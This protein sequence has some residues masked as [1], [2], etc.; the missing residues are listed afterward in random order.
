MAVPTFQQ[1]ATGTGT[2]TAT[3]TF[4]TAPA[5]YH[6]VIAI[7][8]SSTSH[9]NLAIT[10]YTKQ[11]FINQSGGSTTIWSKLCGAGESTSVTVTG[12]ATNTSIVVRSY[13]NLTATPLDQTASAGSTSATTL[14]LTTASTTVADELCI[15]GVGV[16]GTFSSPAFDNSFVLKQNIS[17]L[18]IGEKIIS[19]TGTV[20]VN[21]SWTTARSCHALI[22]TFK[23]G[24]PTP[25]PGRKQIG[26]SIKLRSGSGNASGDPTPYASRTSWANTAAIKLVNGLSSTYYPWNPIATYNTQSGTFDDYQIRENG[27]AIFDPMTNQWMQV[28]TTLDFNGGAPTIS[29]LLSNNGDQWTYHPQNPI[30]GSGTS[31]TT[32][33]E[34]PY[35]CKKLDG[36]MYRDSSGRALIYCEEIPGSEG[37]QRGVYLYRSAPYTLNDWTYAARVLDYGTVANTF[38]RSDRTSPIVIYTGDTGKEFVMLGEGR[39]LVDASPY[40][41][42]GEV[43]LAYSSDGLTFTMGNSGNALI[44]RASSGYWCQGGIVVDDIIKVGSSWVLLAHGQDGSLPGGATAFNHMGRWITTDQPADWT[45]SSFTEMAGNPFDSVTST[46]MFRGMED[47]YAFC[48]LN[49]HTL[50]F[51]DITTV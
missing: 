5:Q 2:T 12:G 36:T 44:T 24:D 23:G 47:G 50:H 9:V 33:G 41:N 4:S 46:V 18:F 42:E 27:N 32:R 26:Q 6:T 21:P 38:D 30:S 1:F 51:T 13:S 8:Y 48:E 49:R 28:Y 10:G 20:T 37:T 16:Q 39:N 11:G 45:S 29:A 22:V 35:I 40:Y 17:R 3:A 19:A 34:D 43:F 14:A 25:A 31:S 15:V 7:V